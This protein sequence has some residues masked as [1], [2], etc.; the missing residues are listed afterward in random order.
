MYDKRCSERDA[1]SGISGSGNLTIVRVSL[2][3]SIHSDGAPVQLWH[4]YS[5][6]TDS[7][8][9]YDMLKQFLIDAY[10]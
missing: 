5:A 8:G 10:T 1:I 4:I 6:V 7:H 9:L 2:A 3:G